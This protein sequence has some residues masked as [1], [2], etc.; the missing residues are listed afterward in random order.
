[1]AKQR[2]VFPQH[3]MG[4]RCGYEV[5]A[6]GSIKPAPD[7]ADRFEMN[8]RERATVRSL[9]GHIMD[10]CATLERRARVE[11][12]RIWDEICDDYGIE[13]KTGLTFDGERIRPDA[14]AA[15]DDAGAAK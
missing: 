9:L 5:Y 10:H 11:A 7:Y 1:M 13:K 3:K 6:D 15:A 14:N 2:E 12:D 4:K 8:A